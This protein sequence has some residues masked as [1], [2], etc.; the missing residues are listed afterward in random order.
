MGDNLDALIQEVTVDAYGEDEQLW[1]FRQ[2]FEDDGRFPFPALAV[3]TAVDVTAVD[4]EGDER[5]GLIALCWRD[6]KTHLISLLD[7]EP[8]GPLPL[9]TARLLAAY[10]R[11]WGAE[12]LPVAAQEP[13]KQ[14]WVYSPL[15]PPVDVDRPLA[16]VSHGDWN[17]EDE[18]W[19]EPGEPLDPLWLDIID[20]GPRPLYEMEQVIP[21]VTPKYWDTDPIVDAADL[22]HAGR[23]RHAARLLKGLLEEDRRCVDAWA[24]LGNIAFGTQGPKAARGYY[25]TGVAIAERSLTDGF[26]GVLSRGLVD[27]RPFLRCLHGLGLCAWRQRRWDDAD[28]A[29][30]SLVWLDPTGSLTALAC[31]DA[32][33][34]RQRWQRDD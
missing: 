21:G 2:A 17:P 5:R 4:Y 14:A 32:V 13:R 3:G 33:R 6:R 16:L 34:A 30:T 9:A 7:I 23:N 19:G 10:R 31:L 11:W 12:P 28:Q 8:V 27:N 18:Y 20:R 22:H 25:K 29:F 24:H 15:A 26:A 1:A